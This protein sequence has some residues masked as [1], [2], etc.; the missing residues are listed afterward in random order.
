MRHEK[1]SQIQQQHLP[2]HSHN[3]GDGD[4]VWLST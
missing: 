1:Q 2:L 4:I 3:L